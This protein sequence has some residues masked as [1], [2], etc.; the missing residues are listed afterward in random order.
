MFCQ[1]EALPSHRSVQ[2]CLFPDQYFA[3]KGLRGTGST[4]PGLCAAEDLP[5]SGSAGL[6]PLQPGSVLP[7]TI[8][9]LTG[10][11]SAHPRLSPA[12]PG[13]PLPVPGTALTGKGSARNKL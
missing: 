1:A 8:C 9:A 10:P 13:S 6:G 11:V 7:G 3:P 2:V 4:C 5:G 12:G